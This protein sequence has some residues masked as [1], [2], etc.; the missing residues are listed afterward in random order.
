MEDRGG[1][2]VLYRI[3]P[4][5]GDKVVVNDNI[6]DVDYVEGEIKIYDL[7]IIKGT[8]YDNKIEVRVE[9]AYNDI[10]AT[11]SLFLD[12]DIKNSKFAVYPE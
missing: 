1:K 2:I 4:A 6:G 3:D 10:S 5:T 8:F 9:P 12:V 11:R 7:T